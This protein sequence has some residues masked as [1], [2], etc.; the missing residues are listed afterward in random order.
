MKIK[1][2]TDENSDEDK[3]T[4]MENLMSKEDIAKFMEEFRAQLK[5]DRAKILAEVKQDFCWHRDSSDS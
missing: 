5:A 3:E 4:K 2:E 1:D